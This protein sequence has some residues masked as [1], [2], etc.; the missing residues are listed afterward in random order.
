MFSYSRKIHKKEKFTV[1]PI[2]PLKSSMNDPSQPPLQ[3]HSSMSFPVAEFSHNE[4]DVVLH[5]A[6]EN[7]SVDLQAQA[8]AHRIGQKRDVLVLRLETVHTVEEQVRAAAEHKLGV[9]NQSITAGFFDNNTSP[10]DRRVYLEEL[11]R[12]SKKEEDGLVLDDEALNYLLARSESEIDIFEAVDSTRRQKEQEE[13]L[14]CIKGKGG[15]EEMEMPPRLVGEEELKPFIMAMQAYDN[16]NPGGKKRS[17]SVLDTQHYG[18]GKRAR[19]VRSY[20]DQL[21][22]EEFERLCQ[23]G[24]PDSPKNNDLGKDVRKTKSAVKSGPTIGANEPMPAKRGRGRPRRI[25]GPSLLP[26]DSGICSTD[27]RSSGILVSA[28][29][30][31]IDNHPKSSSSN[32]V[33]LSVKESHDHPTFF[34]SHLKVQGNENIETEV[35]LAETDVENVAVFAEK[36]E[37]ANIATEADIQANGSIDKEIE[38]SNVGDS[39]ESKNMLMCNVATEHVLGKQDKHKESMKID[40]DIHKQMEGPILLAPNDMQVIDGAPSNSETSVLDVSKAY[41]ITDKGKESAECKEG[42]AGSILNKTGSACPEPNHPANLVSLRADIGI[43]AE[44]QVEEPIID[45]EP[46]AT[47]RSIQYN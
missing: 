35:R 44:E 14:R 40:S 23:A 9:A 28:S 18:R 32:P 4:Q 15:E 3:E 25:T 29:A 31:E 26:K 27:C 45:P 34:S 16:A 46:V 22:E 19:E 6:P 20:G 21:T 41:L 12:G 17:S 42:T 39:N 8:R 33:S 43:C 37:I 1:D 36:S 24:V 13:W 30:K 11:L 5:Q 7:A 10:E 47:D 38:N 2:E